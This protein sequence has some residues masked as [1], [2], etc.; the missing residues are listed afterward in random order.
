MGSPRNI[1]PKTFD[2]ISH[3][4]QM[5]MVKCDADMLIRSREISLKI[6]CQPAIY[7]ELSSQGVKIGPWF[8]QTFGVIFDQGTC[9]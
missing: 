1:L 6:H 5:A 9:Y 7:D 4:Q 2:N 3:H 8:I